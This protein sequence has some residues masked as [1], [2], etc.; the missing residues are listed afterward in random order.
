MAVAGYF[1]TAQRRGA[2]MQEKKH[3]ADGSIF[4]F[5]RRHSKTV[6]GTQDVRQRSSIL[7]QRDMNFH[8]DTLNDRSDIAR[9]LS[10]QTIPSAI[11]VLIRTQLPARFG[12]GQLARRKAGRMDAGPCM[13][14]VRGCLE[15]YC[16]SISNFSCSFTRNITCHSMKIGFLQL[17]Q[18]KDD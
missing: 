11:A 8:H 5:G 9:I 14:A 16:G 12:N 18:M 7:P 3:G 6:L 10:L 4:V 17:T 15:I 1:T 2:F 13:R